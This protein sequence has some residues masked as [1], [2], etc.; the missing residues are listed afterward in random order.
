LRACVI[1][2]TQLPVP[3]HPE[4]L[5]PVNTLPPAAEAWSVTEVPTVYV[6][7]HVPDVAPALMVHPIEGDAPT[8]VTLPCPEELVPATV[9]R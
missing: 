3:L 4:P 6:P 8:L 2:T 1:E 9:R 5:H 7:E